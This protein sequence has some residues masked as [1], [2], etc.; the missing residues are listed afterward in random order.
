MAQSVQVFGLWRYRNT[1]LALL[2]MLALWFL[3]TINLDSTPPVWWDEGWTLTVARTWVERGY[4]ARLLDGQIAP[5]GLEAAFPTTAS[6]A[7]SFRLLGVGLWQGR[8]VG[9]LYT[10]GAIALTYYLARQLY[11]PK[12]ALGTLFALLLLSMHPQAHTLI[13]GRQVLAEPAMLFF[14]LGGYACLL[15][16]FN[17]SLWFLPLVILL[18]GVALNTKAQALPFWLVSLVAPL[19][20]TIST[21]RWFKSALFVLVL[22]G[23]LVMSRS[24]LALQAAWLHGS[25]LAPVPITDINEVAAIVPDLGSRLF[26]IETVLKYELPTMMGLIYAAWKWKE[27]IGQASGEIDA[28][29]I[30][31]ALL[32]F[33]GTWLGWYLLLANAGITRYLFPPT[34]IASMFVASLLSDWTGHFDLRGMIRQ[35]IQGLRWRR[36]NRRT[37]SALLAVALPAIAVSQSLLILGYLYFISPDTSVRQMAEYIDTQTRSDA[38]IESYDSELFFFLNRRYHYPPDQVHVAEVRYNFDPSVAPDYDPMA[39]NPDYLVL[40]PSPFSS[41][42]RIY[43]RAL[44]SGA[45]KPVKQYRGYELYERIR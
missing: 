34:F 10:L 14:L 4:Y 19:L 35:G 1:A 17:K 3:M 21:R 20:V 15:W 31:L 41:G 13:M 26:A 24:L 36:L 44:S 43:N 28:E 42:W 32:V 5:P 2:F 30:K 16:T 45:F 37:I 7:L 27:R 23:S 25:T 6:V 38:L 9:V 22:F 40:G 29:T 39:A 12:V 33:A 18:W 8:L 11:D